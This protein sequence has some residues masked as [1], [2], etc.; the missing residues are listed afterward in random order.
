MW[1]RIRVILRKEFSQALREP[2]M[3]VLLFMPPLLQLIIFGYAV[4]LDVDHARIA[5]MDMDRTP[6]SRDLLARFEGSGRFDVVATA[7]RAKPKCRPC[8]TAARC[9]P[10]C[11]CCRASRATW[12]RGRPT[13]VQVLVDGTNS[14]TASLVSSL[15]RR[16][17][18]GLF[19]GRR[20]PRSRTRACSSARRR[21]APSTPALPAGDRAQP[22]LVQPRPA[23]AATT[24]C[25]A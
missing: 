16:R 5:W 11:A 25:P 24:S 1:E 7:A 2:R 17:H 3:R 14:N 22:R 12:P 4:N 10:W 15:R 9:R 8:W 6:E 23:T 20:W 21:A 19:H 18:R 13:D